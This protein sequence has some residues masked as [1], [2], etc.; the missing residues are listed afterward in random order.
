[1]KIFLLITVV[2]L[3]LVWGLTGCGKKAASGSEAIEASKTMQTVE[4]KVSYLVGQAQ[5]LYN[6][7]EFQEAVNL[8]QYV[9]TYLDKESQQAK[10]LLEKAK[11]ALVAKAKEAVGSAAEGITNKISNLGK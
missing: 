5:T 9:L 1:M 10:D 7:K 6:S 2:C 4:Q 3:V 11:Q 8:A